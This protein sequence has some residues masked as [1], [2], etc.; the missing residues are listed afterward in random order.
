M[1]S[2][3]LSASIQGMNICP[4]QVEADVSDGLP[5]FAMV[6]YVTSQ[7]KE[8][9]ERVRTA[10]K[11]TGIAIPPK[12]ITV[13]LAPADIRK[14]GAGYDLPITAAI[15]SAAGKIPRNLLRGVLM[16]GEVSLSGKCS[17]VSGILPIV[18]KAREL[19]CHTC[20]LPVQN[21][22]EGMLVPDIQV[23]GVESVRDMC[24]ILQGKRNS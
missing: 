7:V 12:R 2:S 19:G 21:A 13:N 24:E 17:P 20:I 14:E 5:S 18:M 15:L 22:L 11:N 10:L 1:F 16:I 6:G 3:V 4:I 9:Q 23:I 8:A